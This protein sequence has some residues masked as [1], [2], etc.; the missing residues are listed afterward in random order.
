M[1]NIKY[2]SVAYYRFIGLGLV[3]PFDRFRAV[4]EVEPQAHY[5]S[6]T[7]RFRMSVS[8]LVLTRQT[9]NDLTTNDT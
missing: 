9:G 4:S 8:S 6:A 2:G 1:M 3:R 5:K 7:Y